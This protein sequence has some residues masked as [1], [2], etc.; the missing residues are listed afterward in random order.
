MPGYRD[1]PVEH[2]FKPGQSGNPKGGPRG[3]RRRR[4]SRRSKFLDQKISCSIGGRPFK[5]Q[6]REALVTAA[7]MWSL[8]K[9]NFGLQQLLL[10][11][12]D[13]LD[14]K[15]S[16]IDRENPVH[17]IH[18][19][20]SRP[21]HVGCIEAAAEVAGFGVKAY[22]KQKSARVLLE[23]WVVEEALA[24]LGERRLDREQQKLVLEA[25][26]FPK[27]MNWPDWWEPDLRQRG[28]G[29][30]ARQNVEFTSATKPP[31]IIRRSLTDQLA[32]ERERRELWE[33]RERERACRNDPELAA[34][35]GLPTRG[36][37]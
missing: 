13:Q 21:D 7:I 4:S 2:R 37:P 25:V 16:H 8:A 27:K 31:E 36:A 14:E 24:K 35:Y 34:F 15:Q 32:I 5:G 12:R 11:L 22:R 33:R 19:W 6:R 10:K 29:W 20:P 3:P 28:K 1:P 18:D 26:R 23:N 9:R 30:R 17:V